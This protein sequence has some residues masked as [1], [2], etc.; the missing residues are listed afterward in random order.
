MSRYILVSEGTNVLYPT[1]NSNILGHKHYRRGQ[2]GWKG[3]LFVKESQRGLNIECIDLSDTKI[4]PSHP[5]L[6]KVA[7]DKRNFG[8]I[9]AVYGVWA[10]SVR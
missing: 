6:A 3:N 9:P 7:V 10:I 1:L 4:S 2:G 5:Q 8:D